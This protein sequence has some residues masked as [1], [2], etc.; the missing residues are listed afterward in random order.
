MKATVTQRF[1][2]ST[3]LAHGL[4]GVDP[5]QNGGEPCPPTH[6]IFEREELVAAGQRGGA[7]QEDVLDIVNFKHGKGLAAH[8]I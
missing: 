7:V 5:V 6:G 8:C 3:D 1:S 4:R 2:F